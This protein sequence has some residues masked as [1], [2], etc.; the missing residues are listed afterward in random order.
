AYCPITDFRGADM[1]YEWLYYETRVRLVEEANGTQL[2]NGISNDDLLAYSAELKEAYET[3]FNGLGLV[4]ENGEKLTTDNLL[5]HIE[6][7][8]KAEFDTTLEQYTESEGSVDA[9][10]KA[11]IADIESKTA[12]TKLGEN[13]WLIFKT[14]ESG[15]YTGEY[16]YNIAEHLYF[17]ANNQTLKVVNA[18]SNQGLEWAS[19]NEDNLFGSATDVY[20]PFEYLSW[21]LDS[22][23][24]NGVGYNDTNMTWDEYMDTEEGQYLSMQIRMTSAVDYLN[25]PGDAT[26]ATYWYVRHGVLDRDTS[27]A[28]E[29]TLFYS[30]Y[31]SDAVEDDNINVGFAWLRQHEGDYDVQEAYTWLADV[32]EDA[33]DDS[34]NSDNSGNGGGGGHASSSVNTDAGTGSSSG[35]TTS[36]GTFTDVSTSAYYYDAVEW[37]VANGIT[38]GTSDTTF[39]PEI[40]C[41]RAQIVTFLWRAAGSPEAESENPFTDVAEDS[42]YYDAILWAVANG[43]PTA[44]LKPPSHPTTPAHAAR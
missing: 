30:L 12:Y 5:A 38:T 6:A 27:F 9:A 43:I 11:M 4:D 33:S 1:A 40:G 44:L 42:Y 14:D 23:E 29:S 31:T 13:N 37:A 7:L 22:V 10:V 26:P 15:A 16:T 8:M 34:G 20:S 28:V 36:T 35:T 3:Y 2:Y 24:G 18:F 41:S 19:Q 17:L 21:E 25:D 32:L 39:S